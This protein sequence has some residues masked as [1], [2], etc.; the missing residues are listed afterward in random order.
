[1]IDPIAFKLGP[2]SVHWYGILYG[3]GV[4]LSIWVISQLDK[5][6]HVFKDHN[7][8]FDLLFWVFLV[9]VVLGGRLG[10]V[11][12]YN[13]SFY[14]QNP[15]KILAIWG[16]G[17][18]FHGGLIGSFAI[19]YWYAKKHKIDFLKLA[20]I[21]VIPGALAQGI[22][23]IGNFINAE[24][25][26]R[27]I[28]NPDWAWIGGNFGDGILRYPSQLFQSFSLIL[29]AGIL[30]VIYRKKPKKGTLLASYLILNGLFRFITEFW[31]EPDQQIGFIFNSL[32]L[33]QLFGLAVS[34]VG[35]IGFLHL[36]KKA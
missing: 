25:I 15:A 2:I 29:L 28:N 18:S 22:G 3:V 4:I 7:K 26:G 12:F 20:D 27:P 17:M 13:P 36:R 21:A 14:L 8:I 6:R 9:G 33:G 5:K 35:V 34:L 23:R 11:L 30:Y 10:Y 19:A 31:R 1:M 24:L 16:G 32:T